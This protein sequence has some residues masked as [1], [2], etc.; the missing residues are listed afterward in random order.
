MPSSPSIAAVAAD[1]PRV[2]VADDHT[3]VAEAVGR[4]LAPYCDVV[5]I[6]GDGRAVIAESDR[7]TPDVV[8]LDIAMPILNGID[9]GRE[10]KK[11]LPRTRLVYL[12]MSEDVDL[13]AEAFSIGASAFLLKSSA[14]SELVDAIHAALNGQSYVTARM[15]RG[16]ASGSAMRR[17]MNTVC[18]TLFVVACVAAPI[19]AQ[20]QDSSSR[21]A[22]MV[23]VAD[24]PAADAGAAV[25]PAGP[26]PTPEHTGIRALFA[27]LYDD[28]KHLPSTENLW[29][30]LGGG[31]LAAASHPADN[32][33][34]SDLINASWAHPT[35]AFGAVLGETY[36]LGAASVVT[37]AAGRIVGNGKVSHV[38]MDMLQALAMSNLMVQTL[39]YTTRRER[40][41]GSGATSFPSGHASDTFAIATALERHAGWKGAVPAYLF[42]TYVAASRL[43]DN[44]HYLSDVVFGSAVGIISGR[45]VT[46]HGREIPITVAAVPGGAAIVYVRSGK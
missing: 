43:H 37:Y 11:R 6:V 26:V 29:W 46:R 20:A 25:Q 2:L 41:D 14:A 23:L 42:A 31:A 21:P 15:Y 13:A 44:R 38:G 30:A 1:R 5:G 35:F 24:S 7:L 40:P 27:D 8:V 9:A 12:T 45:T 36:T 33:V 28:T 19:A 16:T 32:H 18:R 17:V 39:K 22:E 10:I 34:N 4:L 3:L